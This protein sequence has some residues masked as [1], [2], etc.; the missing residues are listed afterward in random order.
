MH[1]L[2]YL[3]RFDF[4][5]TATT[6]ILILIIIM[7]I[8]II[9]IIKLRWSYHDWCISSSWNGKVLEAQLSWTVFMKCWTASVRVHAQ[10]IAWS[11]SASVHSLWSNTL[12]KHFIAHTLTLCYVISRW[13]KVINYV[14]HELCSF[15]LVNYSWR[16][17][18][19]WIM[20]GTL[21]VKCQTLVC[22]DCGEP[23]LFL[24]TQYYQKA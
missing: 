8:I 14:F 19:G 24:F 12:P 16:F 22:D 18:G 6:V 1:L 7:I 17:H 5:T 4:I 3:Q 15:M 21:S 10:F 13:L 23:C 9:I 20:S 2:L 11:W